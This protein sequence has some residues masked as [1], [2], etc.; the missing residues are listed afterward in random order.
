M[1]RQSIEVAAEP[2]TLF[3]LSRGLTR[4]GST[5]TRSSRRRGLP[6]AATE[7]AG[8]IGVPGTGAWPATASA[9]RR[10]TS[11]STRRG[12]LRRRDDQGSL[13]LSI[14]HRG[15]G[16]SIDLRAGP[17][18]AG[19]SVHNTPCHGRPGLLSGPLRR[20]LRPRETTPS[21]RGAQ[22]DHVEL[23]EGRLSRGPSPTFDPISR[24]RQI[25][26][27]RSGVRP[28]TAEADL[29]RVGEGRILPPPGASR[30]RG[31]R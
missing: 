10:G 31:S 23:K 11:P 15:P 2:D 14:L 28:S 16:G 5:G 9:W 29:S 7:S 13:D 4:D 21:T 22:D 20:H 25:V 12:R 24:D 27:V 18:V 8:P 19:S 3:D 30:H 1:F 6:S 26:E 17:R